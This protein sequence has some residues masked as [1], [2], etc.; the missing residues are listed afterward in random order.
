MLD[1]IYIF[2]PATLIFLEKVFA[3]MLLILLCTK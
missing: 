1:A 2:S 3:I